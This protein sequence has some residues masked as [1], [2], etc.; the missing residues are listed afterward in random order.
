MKLG[1]MVVAAVVLAHVV[2]SSVASATAVVHFGPGGCVSLTHSPEGTCVITTDCQGENTA[3][4]E[5]QFDCVSAAGAV[6]RHSFGVGG[7]DEDEEFDTN[8]KCEECLSTTPPKQTQPA[9]PVP[10]LPPQPKVSVI[11]KRVL[12]TLN[13][14]R[15]SFRHAVAVGASNT[16]ASA[17]ARKRSRDS[18]QHAVTVEAGSTIVSA[19]APL[20]L[21]SKSSNSSDI[22]QYGPENCIQ[23]YSKKGHCFIHTQCANVDLSNFNVG[24]VCVDKSGVPVRHLYGIDSFD[25]EEIFDTMLTCEH[26]LGLESMPGKSAL[27]TQVQS[28]SKEIS[29]VEAMMHNLSANV[30]MLNKEVFGA[31]QAVDATGSLIHQKAVREKIAPHPMAVLPTYK[32]QANAKQPAAAAATPQVGHQK[33]NRGFLHK[34]D[35]VV[36]HEVL[37]RQ[38]AVKRGVARQREHEVTRDADSGKQEV[39]DAAANA[40]RASGSQQETLDEEETDDDT[41][42]MEHTADTPAK[43]GDDDT[44]AKEGDEDTP[45]MR[46]T[47][48]DAD[49]L[50]REDDDDNSE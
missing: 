38:G 28:L 22:V 20:S 13:R 5:F 4:V 9:A 18:A 12:V 33:T 8:V 7:F 43:E 37:E 42:D 16:T 32:G 36:K 29:A 40:R 46:K 1:A 34:A 24:M 6:E 35:S 19:K 21:K 31:E 10:R 15:D 39:A 26:C 47:A 14:S 41:A 2:G 48:V 49:T 25:A 23:T 17:K 30:G 3:N 45:S 50:A 44:P 11:A 27:N